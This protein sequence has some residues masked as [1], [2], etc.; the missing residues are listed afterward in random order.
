MLIVLVQNEEILE[1][2]FSFCHWFVLFIVN[3]FLCFPS[4]LIFDAHYFD[5]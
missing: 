4:I 1:W 3:A 2:H 5:N